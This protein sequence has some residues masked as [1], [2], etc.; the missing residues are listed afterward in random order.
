ML[1]TQMQAL[2]KL[3][4][5]DSPVISSWPV[6]KISDHVDSVYNQLQKEYRLKGVVT[7]KSCLSS[8]S[9]LVLLTRTL[10]NFYCIFIHNVQLHF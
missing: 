6:S 1:K 3:Q 8:L 7:G 5:T 4:P 9:S 10:P 2:A